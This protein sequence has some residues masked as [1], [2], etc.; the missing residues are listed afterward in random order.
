MK[1][2]QAIPLERS[3]VK[4]DRSNRMSESPDRDHYWA[5]LRKLKARIES[6]EA[7]VSTVRRDVNRIDR[8]QLREAEKLPSGNHGPET[9]GALSPPGV[10]PGVP[11]LLFGR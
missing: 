11:D 10:P 3:E 4:T 2:A 6:L 5:T 7:Q 9:L 1:A 8:K